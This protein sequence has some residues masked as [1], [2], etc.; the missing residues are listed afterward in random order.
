MPKPELTKKQDEAI[1][2]A[3]QLGLY[4][5]PRESRKED[6]ADEIGISSQAANERMRRAEKQLVEDY[7][8]DD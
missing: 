2:V 5:V 6:L 8:E 4:E 1:R 7:L 3:L